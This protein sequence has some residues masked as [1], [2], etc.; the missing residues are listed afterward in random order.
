MPIN[1][2][3]QNQLLAMVRKDQQMRKQQW[4]EMKIVY[5]R[6]PDAHTPEY[7]KKVSALQRELKSLDSAHTKTM[8]SIITQFGWPGKSLVGKSGA[9]AAWLLV[10]HADHAV[11]FQKKCLA[12]MK[13]AAI[14]GDVENKEIAYLTDRI[15]VHEGKKQLYGTQYKGDVHGNYTPFPIDNP[16]QLAIRRKK[17][18][19][20]LFEKYHREMT[21]LN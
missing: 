4:Q 12:L 19:L 16:K 7:K 13:K 20:G 11:P 8:R 15:L 5:K 9:F 2:K 1:K 21:R 3:L 17:M 14:S 18:G 6:Y 10:Q